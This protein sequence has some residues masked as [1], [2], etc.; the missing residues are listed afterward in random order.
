MPQI[1]T[2]ISSAADSWMPKRRSPWRRISAKMLIA[3]ADAPTAIAADS[4]TVPQ[5]QTMP[6]AM[7]SA[8]M[9]T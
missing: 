7:S 3:A 4:A 2:P 8:A 6:G 5:S 1:A 9:P